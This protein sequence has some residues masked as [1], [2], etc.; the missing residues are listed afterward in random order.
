MSESFELKEPL[1]LYV[2]MNHEGKF[3]RSKG[4]YGNYSRSQWVDSINSA[5][6]YGKIGPAKAT[7]SFYANSDSELPAPQLVCLRAD[8]AEVV[9]RSSKVVEEL[10]PFKECVLRGD[11]AAHMIFDRKT[12][13]VWDDG[14]IAPNYSEWRIRSTYETKAVKAFVKSILKGGPPEPFADWI[15]ENWKAINE[16][17]KR[18]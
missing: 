7:I 9:D 4:G 17:A 8:K 11:C 14:R 3:F 16:G 13:A 6:I 10:R 2:V 5:K 15:R 18:R 12:V 1:L